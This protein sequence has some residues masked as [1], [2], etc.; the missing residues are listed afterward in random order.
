MSNIHIGT[1]RRTSKK[2]P[3]SR[4][5]FGLF[6]AAAAIALTAAGVRMRKDR[7]ASP[8]TFTLPS[9][10][11]QQTADTAEQT[12][13]AAAQPDSP[14]TD[15]T[16]AAPTAP[17]KTDTQATQKTALPENGDEWEDSEQTLAIQVM[18]QNVSYTRPAGGAVTKPYSMNSLVYSR[19]M[20]D[21]RTHNGLDIAA[22]EGETVRSAAEGTVAGVSKD[23]LY[24]VTVVVNQNDGWM[25]YYRG[26]S[27]NP[28]VREGE[29]VSA[30][31]TLGTVGKIPCESADGSHLHIEVKKENRF[32]DPAVALS[33]Q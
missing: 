17:Q 18:G 28:A 19:T 33:I 1:R 4:A 8:E 26:L 32:F 31:T 7:A 22:A 25:V 11:S 23:P 30:G 14:S 13:A 5:S 20:G 9:A 24:G 15:H 21:W 6:L 29:N 10:S 27:E 12:Q 3:A 16:T 2:N